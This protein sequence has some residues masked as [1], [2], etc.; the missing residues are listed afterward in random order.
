MTETGIAEQLNVG[1]STISRDVKALK[2]MSEQFVF[3]LAKSDLAIITNSVLRILR[4]YRF[5]KWVLCGSL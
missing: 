5:Q 2:E 1:Q 4:C 3:D